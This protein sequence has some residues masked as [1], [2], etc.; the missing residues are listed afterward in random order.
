MTQREPWPK[1]EL[2]SIGGPDM[3]MAER[4]TRYQANVM[5]IREA[6]HQ[7]PSPM[8][9]TLDPTEVEAWLKASDGTAARLARAIRRTSGSPAGTTFPSPFT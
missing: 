4:V 1:G 8:A 6:G 9:D 3:P 2:V 5:A 7:V